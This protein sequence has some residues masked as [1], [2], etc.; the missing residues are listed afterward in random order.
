[1]IER[2]LEAGRLVPIFGGPIASAGSYHLVW[3]KEREGR[4]PLVS[5]RDWL[6]GEISP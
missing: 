6:A 5:F 4:A 3:P 1:L 2:D